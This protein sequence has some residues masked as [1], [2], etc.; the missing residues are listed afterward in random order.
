MLK[1]L[2]P[3]LVPELALAPPWQRVQAPQEEVPVV[4]MKFAAQPMA[5]FLSNTYSL[6]VVVQVPKLAVTLVKS[7]FA[8]VTVTA[9]PDA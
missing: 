2:V 7:A 6:L 3:D 1:Y 8:V 4:W 5:T 9:V